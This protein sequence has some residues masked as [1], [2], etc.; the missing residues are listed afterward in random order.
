MLTFLFFSYLLFSK[1]TYGS[2]GDKRNSLKVFYYLTF[3]QIL[4]HLIWQLNLHDQKI[5]K[6]HSACCTNMKNAID[7]IQ[8][9]QIHYFFWST[10]LFS[11]RY[12]PGF[13]DIFR[14]EGKWVQFFYCGFA[15]PLDTGCKF[16]VH[17]INLTRM[18]VQ[19]MSCVQRVKHLKG[20]RNIF[21]TLQ[22][23]VK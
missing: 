19:F 11:Y 4:R 9:T 17:N 22:V 12:C 15:Y 16:N 21:K 3:C 2:K 18:H 13:Y 7:I 23:K 20:L 1:G 6:R 14:L 5:K 10:Y 8:N